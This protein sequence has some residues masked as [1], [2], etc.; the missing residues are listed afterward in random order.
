LSDVLVERLEVRQFRSY[1]RAA[2]E[3]GHGVTVLFG[4]NGA[5]KTNLLE[6][7]YIGCS[8]RSTRTRNEREL[9]RFGAEGARIELHT[10]GAADA[11]HVV[12]VVLRPGERK[13]VRIDGRAVERVP[14][15]EVRPFVCVFM[16]DRL[17]LLKGP[18]APRRAHLDELVGALWPA[19]IEDRRSYARTLAQRNALLAAIR[20]GRATQESLPAWDAEL[21]LNAIPL[22]AG[23]DQAV[24]LLSAQLARRAR[25]LG[26]AGEVSADYRAQ[27]GAAS[28]EAFVAE[29][30]GRLPHDLQRGFSTYGPHRD[31]LVLRH[32]GRALRS[33]GSQGEQRLALLALLLAERD[34]LERERASVPLMLLDDV[35]SELDEHARALLVKELA[36][37]GQ[38]VITTADPRQLPAEARQVRMLEVPADVLAAPSAPNATH[39]ASVRVRA[40]AFSGGAA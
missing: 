13:A 5:G 40:P 38:S 10:V 39:S 26:L 23:R 11:P 15:G 25:E 35:F 21:A 32:D 31:E 37:G 16:P 30:Q 36:G 24:K 4:P 14:A 28:V 2:C 33:Y 12:S 20:A 27:P 22:R 17:S 8:G 19:R 3:L 1:E 34:L 29:L 18:P 7:L 9:V 6:A